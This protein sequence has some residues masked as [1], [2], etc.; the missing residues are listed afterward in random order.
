MKT[1][2]QPCI[3][4]PSRR[5]ATNWLRMLSPCL[6]LLLPL[7]VIAQTAD[8]KDAQIAALKAEIE[9]LKAAQRQNPPAAQPAPAA[10]PAAS[11]PAA[12]APAE[13]ASTGTAAPATPE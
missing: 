1:H 6:A 4:S 12:S 8:D 2:Q 7:P 9:Q 13:T 5:H 3:T 10:T 11:P